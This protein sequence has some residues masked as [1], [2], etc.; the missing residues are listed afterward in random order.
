MLVA[1]GACNT[2]PA[3]AAQYTG[4]L[5]GLGLVSRLSQFNREIYGAQG[6]CTPKN[7]AQIIRMQN[8]KITKTTNYDL[9]GLVIS[10]DHTYNTLCTA[11]YFLNTHARPVPVHQQHMLLMTSLLSVA[12]LAFTVQIIR[13]PVPCRNSER[14]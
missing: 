5:V 13:L 14:G 10:G 7:K 8:I 12:S 4:S 1:G 9:D 3:R 2:A 11:L 6:P